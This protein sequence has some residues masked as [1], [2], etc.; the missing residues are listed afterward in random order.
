MF[1][2]MLFGIV[3]EFHDFLK[4]GTT[5]VRELDFYGFNIIIFHNFY[6]FFRLFS[7]LILVSIVD[8]FFDGFWLHFG[9]SWDHFYDF[10]GINFLMIFGHRFGMPFFRFGTKNG[11]ISISRG[12]IPRVTFSTLFSTSIMGSIFDGFFIILGWFWDDF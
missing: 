1:L 3:F 5:M 6:T 7:T 4:N 10:F 8:R 11:A 2:L 12:G 9:P